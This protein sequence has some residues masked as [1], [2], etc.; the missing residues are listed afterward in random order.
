[1][2]LLQ[3]YRDVFAWTY[4][5]MPGLDLGLV[6]HSINVDPGVRSV[7]QLARVFHNE[8]EAQ[9]IQEVKKLLT[10]GFIKPIQHPKWLSNIVPM[11]KKNGQIRCYVD[12]RNPN[13]ACPKDEFPL[14]NIDLLVDLAVGSS[15]FSFMDGYSGYNQIRMAAKD[16][17]KTA[18]RIPIGNF[19]YIVMPFGLKNAGATY[20]RT[21]IAIFHDMMHEEMEDYV[22]DIVVKSKIRTGHFQVLEQVF[23][24][25]RKYKL[26]M[27]PMKCAFGVSARKFLGFLVHHKGVSVDLAKATAIATMKRLTTV[28]ELKSFPG[29]VSYI[30][31]FVL[32]LASVT[33]GLS[34]LL[35]KGTKFT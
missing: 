19:Y 2:A 30:R 6:V 26:R 10:A 1:M 7:V 35:K 17:E 14:P 9:I 33:T 31:R 27:N 22:D 5:E 34:K 28:R 32:G 23:E 20:Q 11:E 24:R 3:K 12:F 25:C 4:D 13:K 8:V 15:M 21:M 16:V 18:F 29:R